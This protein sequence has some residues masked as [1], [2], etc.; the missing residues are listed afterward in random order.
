MPQPLKEVIVKHPLAIRWFHWCNFPILLCMIWSGMLIYWANDEYRITLGKKEVFHFFPESFYKS[1][2]IPFRLAE[3]MNWHFTFMWLFFIN[4]LLYIVFTL[5][6]GQWRY[7]L[8]NKR[9]FKEAFQVVLHDLHIKR[10]Q[11]KFLKYNAAQRIAYTSVIVMG[12]GSLITGLAI[13]KPVQFGWAAWLCGG[14]KAARLEHFI[15]TIGYVLFF[16]VHILQ[17]IKTG[18]NNFQAMITGFEISKLPKT[19]TDAKSS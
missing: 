8:P 19:K 15:L 12:I 2:G 18:W 7:L 3:G 16:I 11:P 10:T 14:Y 17:V 1:L 6:S 9:S 13:Y 5:V 4:G